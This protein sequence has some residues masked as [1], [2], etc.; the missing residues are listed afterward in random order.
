MWL[1]Y[2]A[3]IIDTLNHYTRLDISGSST[4]VLVFIIYFIFFAIYL[5]RHLTL[6]YTNY[7]KYTSPQYDGGGFLAGGSGRDAAVPPT[8]IFLRG[9]KYYF[10]PT[11]NS[12]KYSII[13]YIL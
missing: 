2:F 10:A 13:Y 4:T 7:N 3:C 8:T 5:I 12:K 6:P 11:D 1:T 9:Q